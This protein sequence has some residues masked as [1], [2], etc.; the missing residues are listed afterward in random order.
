LMLQTPCPPALPGAVMRA[1]A[2]R[3][4]LPSLRLM[5]ALY[6]RALRPDHPLA[7]DTWTPLARWLLYLRSHW[8]RMP[9][10]LL[11]WHLTRK[12]ITSLRPSRET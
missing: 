12:F 10:H 4:R 8:I 1:A 5:D 7:A 2:H 11:C 9:A 3:K 6:L